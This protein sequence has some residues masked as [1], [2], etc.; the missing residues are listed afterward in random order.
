MT[1]LKLYLC[2]PKFFSKLR[3]K[4]EIKIGASPA[5]AGDGLDNGDVPVRLPEEAVVGRLM[6]PR[7]DDSVLQRYKVQNMMSGTEHNVRYRT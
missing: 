7:Q 6:H 3:L 4:N 5:G 2:T 1:F